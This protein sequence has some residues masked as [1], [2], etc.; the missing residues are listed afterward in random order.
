MCRS[1]RCSMPA[2][3]GVP[4]D[5]R[6]PSRRTEESLPLTWSAVVPETAWRVVRTAAGRRALHVMLL[7]SGVFVLGVL[8]GERAQAAE[9]VPSPGTSPGRSSPSP[10]STHV[11]NR[12]PQPQQSGNRRPPLRGR[13]ATVAVRTPRPFESPRRAGPDLGCVPWPRAWPGVSYGPWRPGSCV[14]SSTWWRR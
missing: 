10:R 2:W 11:R 1:M 13:K 6:E 14:R 12:R 9:G 3:P 4:D 8:C 5:A 7:M